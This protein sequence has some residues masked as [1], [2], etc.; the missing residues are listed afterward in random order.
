VKAGDVLVATGGGLASN[1][2]IESCCQMMV[3]EM[4]RR[5]RIEAACQKASVTGCLSAM[6]CPGASVGACRAAFFQN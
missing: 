6:P 4:G 5:D 2:Q 1:A 3:R